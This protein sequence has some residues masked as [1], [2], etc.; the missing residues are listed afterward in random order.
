MA[1][2][3]HA[4]QPLSSIRWSHCSKRN[5]LARRRVRRYWKQSSASPT[6]SGISAYPS[7][8]ADAVRTSSELSAAVRASSERAAASR[9][10]WAAAAFRAA[11][12]SLVP[13]SVWLRLLSVERTYKA[14]RILPAC[15]LLDLRYYFLFLDAAFLLNA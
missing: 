14:S 10:T 6:F 5:R 12:R 9:A 8:L 2:L 15:A 4:L 1:M 13:V 11:I 7:E 3:F